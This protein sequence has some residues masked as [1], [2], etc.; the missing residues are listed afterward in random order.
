MEEEN[1]YTVTKYLLGN[2][3]HNGDIGNVLMGSSWK[4][5]INWITGWVEL[6]AV[7]RIFSDSF[8]DLGKKHKDAIS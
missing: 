7:E 8:S 5:L 3:H 1:T 6:Q 2:R 4:E